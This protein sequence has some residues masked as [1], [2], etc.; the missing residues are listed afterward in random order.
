[1]RGLLDELLSSG[2]EFSVAEY[3]LSSRHDV[4]PTGVAHHARLSR[5]AGRL[6][7]GTPYYAGYEVRPFGSMQDLFDAFGDKAQS[8][9]RELFRHAKLGKIWWKI[10]PDTASA[11]M[12]CPRE[13]IIRAME[14]WKRKASP[15]FARPT[16][17][18]AIAAE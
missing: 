6:Q 17:A 2:E 18:S 9:M 15:K 7:Q 12:N 3:D 16:R 1:V 14:S 10:D 8:F 5:T 4:R 11:A 13:H